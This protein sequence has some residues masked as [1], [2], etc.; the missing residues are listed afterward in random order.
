MEQEVRMQEAEDLY[1]YSC[2]HNFGKG[3]RDRKSVV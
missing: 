3:I 1:T 2:A